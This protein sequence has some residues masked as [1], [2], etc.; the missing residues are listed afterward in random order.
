M[1]FLRSVLL[2]S[3]LLA[4]SAFAADIDGK[5]AGSMDGGPGGAITIGYTFKADGATLTGTTTGPDGMEIKITN[6]K[7]TGNKISFDVALDFGGMPFTMSYTG[8]LVGDKLMLKADFAGMPFEIT[9][10]KA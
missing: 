9:A 1:N 10:K 2:G 5:W 6:G 7:V 3:V 8:E 4:S